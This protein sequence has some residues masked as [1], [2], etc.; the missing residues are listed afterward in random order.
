M[1]DHFGADADGVHD[2]DPVAGAVGFEDVSAE[3]E[4]RS[5]AVAVGAELVFHFLE[6]AHREERAEFPDGGFGD[7]F[8]K[9]V[10]ERVEEGFAGFK[11]DVADESVADDDVDLIVENMETFDRAAVVDDRFDAF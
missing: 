5:A 1:G 3:A 10:F 9:V 11:E 8:F 4:E 2:G 7:F 6:R